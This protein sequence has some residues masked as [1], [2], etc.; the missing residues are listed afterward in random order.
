MS[1]SNQQQSVLP[2]EWVERIFSHMA[3]NYGAKFADLWAG[4]DIET[5]KRYWGLKLGGFAG[6]P[7]S[8]KAALEALDERP[9][10]PTLPEFIALC[11]I[12]A[13]REG[14]GPALPPPAPLSRDDASARVQEISA[15]VG[16]SDPHAA[17]PWWAHALRKK[18]LSGERLLPVQI[19]LA[20]EALGEVWSMGKVEITERLAA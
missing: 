2:A 12:S 9:F 8:I 11:R 18:Y 16:K 14:A 1:Q 19:N 3:C 20:S 5:V 10:P 15:K 4:Q 7:L 17:G 13:R 6:H